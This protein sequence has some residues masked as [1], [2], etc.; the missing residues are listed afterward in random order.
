[1]PP[2][3]YTTNLLMISAS[4]LVAVAF[5]TLLERKTLSYMQL[6]KGPNTVGPHGIIQPLADG[7][8]L[9]LKEPIRPKKSSPTTFTAAPMMALALALFLWNTLPMP[10]PVLS[11][12]LGLLLLMATSSMT[13]YSTLWSGWASNSKYALMGALRAVAQMISYEVTL[14][15]ILMCLAIQTGGYNLE[16]FSTTQERLYLIIPAWPLMMMWYISTLAETNRSPF[17]LT[18]GESELVSGFNVEYTGGMFALLF[19]AEYTNIILMNTL[20]CILFLNPGCTKTN[21]FTTLL[22]MESALLTM[23]FLWIRASYPRFRYDQLMQLLWKQFLPM[24]LT[25]CLLY[26]TAPLTLAALS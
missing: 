10:Y 22:M 9:L 14:G 16:L 7:M 1:M 13:V 24:T 4:A 2:L 3:S 25:M 18:E 21:T 8:K 15:L 23:G 26:T 17:D 5:L 19:L 6:R 20:T 11:L 12:N